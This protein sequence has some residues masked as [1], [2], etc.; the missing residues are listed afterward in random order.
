VTTVAKIHQGKLSIRTRILIN[1]LSLFA[2]VFLI[3]FAVF[4]LLVKEYIESSVREQL[5]GV[6]ET[7]NYTLQKP[8]P[9]EMP[10]TEPRPKPIPDL[11]DLPKGQVAR[12]EVMIV[13][14]AYTLIYP[15]ASIIYNQA[16]DEMVSLAQR[17][18]DT[19]SNLWDS[20]IM[21]LQASDREYYYVSSR[22]SGD[23]APE[24][25]FLIY[26]IDMT[27]ISAFANRINTVLLAVMGMASLMAFVIAVIL[28]GKLAKPVRELTR[29][30]VRIGKGDFS[31]SEARYQDLELAE[32][33]E[34]MNKAAAQLDAYDNDQK[35][36]FQ[37][38]SHEL[39]TPLQTIKSNAEGVLHGIL[40]PKSSSKLIIGE[41]D[42][43]TEMV[44]DLL[45][46]SR[47]DSFQ[48]SMAIEEYD[49]REL[50]SS[51]A[52]R[53]RSLANERG[54]E[55]VFYFDDDPVLFRCDAKDLTRAFSNLISN[56]IRY[57]RGK[58]VFSCQLM[59]DRITVSI[60]DDGEG[61][62]PQ[63]LPHVLD[64]FYK[65]PRG[66]HGIGLSIVKAIATL[67]KGR[68][69][70]RSSDAGSSFSLILPLGF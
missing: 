67:Y 53:Q 8:H 52:E 39:R 1:V 25:G 63:D 49:L 60:V 41:T 43:L 69:D 62:A 66:K 21:H 56:A 18:L 35:T 9:V 27:S 64:R 61:I 26:F 31:R 2:L 17:L 11:R 42:E 57:A 13:S 68:I 37:N 40:E 33:A 29:F 20:S 23:N 32:L 30:A 4:N 28:S 22:L 36:F 3:V 45:C 6:Y 59:E 34:S 70:V 48:N 12:T 65:G 44:E 38:V 10:L 47:I 58:I 19:K 51:C 14:D 55:Y 50:L 54:L 15:D 5:Q 46:I 16:Y 7:M 24:A